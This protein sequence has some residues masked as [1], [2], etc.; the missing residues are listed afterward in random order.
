MNLRAATNRAHVAIQLEAARVTRGRL[1]KWRRPRP[2]AERLLNE[3]RR[4]MN[5][6]GW[7]VYQLAVGRTA[8]KLSVN[9]DCLCRSRWSQET[10]YRAQMGRTNT[11]VANSDGR[12]ATSGSEWHFA[13]AAKCKFHLALVSW[14]LNFN[15]KYN[16]MNNH[17]E[18]AKRCARKSTVASPRSNGQSEARLSLCSNRHNGF[19]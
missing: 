7:A 18:T 4:A 6:E 2:L 10:E 1:R 19:D 11:Y 12:A 14:S 8:I 17:R 3:I 16:N 9:T 13:S 15:A 5:L